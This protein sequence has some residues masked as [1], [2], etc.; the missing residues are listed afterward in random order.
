VGWKKKLNDLCNK[1]M[2]DVYIS[3]R[4][5]KNGRKIGLIYRSDGGYTESI[6]SFD[7]QA[8]TRKNDQEILEQHF[9][10]V[11]YNSLQLCP[12]KEIYRCKRPCGSIGL[13]DIEAP[14]FSR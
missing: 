8:A 12:I 9:L 10:A 4:M 7:G 5:V 11:P 14:T 6:H 3:P 1:K 2:C 13:R